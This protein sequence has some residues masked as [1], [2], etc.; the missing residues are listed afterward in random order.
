MTRRNTT[1][2]SCTN[3]DVLV[4][5]TE[6]KL[7]SITV[8]GATSILKYYYFG[9]QRV[10]MRTTAGVSYTH[11]DHLGSSCIAI[12]QTGTSFYLRQTLS[13]HHTPATR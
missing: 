8:G 10:A 9:K 11:G 13:H 2:W 7:T 12:T 6:N 5:D 3:G 1:S 4:Y